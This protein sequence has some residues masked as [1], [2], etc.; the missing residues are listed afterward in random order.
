MVRLARRARSS[1][2]PSA[3]G[4]DA[5]P[6]PSLRMTLIESTGW[7]K[8]LRRIPA[9]ETQAA[10]DELWFAIAVDHHENAALPRKARLHDS[11]LLLTY[12]TTQ[13]SLAERL[14]D[15]R[16]DSGAALP[17]PALVTLRAMSD[18]CA[19]ATYYTCL[20]ELSLPPRGFDGLDV[21][22]AGT[23]GRLSL[24]ML[25]ASTTV[26]LDQ[27][28][29]AKSVGMLLWSC[30]TGLPAADARKLSEIRTSL[31][32]AFCV[33]VDAW[34]AG[35]EEDLAVVGH[36]LKQTVYG[37]LGAGGLLPV[38]PR[39]PRERLVEGELDLLA[40]LCA[41]GKNDLVESYFREHEGSWREEEASFRQGLSA[42]RG[43]RSIPQ[44]TPEPESW[45]LDHAHEAAARAD[46]LLTEAEL[47]TACGEPATGWA[48]WVRA[49][50]VA[51]GEPDT[52]L[53]LARL[54]RHGGGDY[55][56]VSFALAEA[57]CCARGEPAVRRLAKRFLASG[58]RE[59]ALFFEES[60]HS[61]VGAW[62]R[63]VA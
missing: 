3:G 56:G 42:F 33:A 17:L 2:V 23:H 16:L 22:W 4:S 40:V 45:L 52:W 31:P 5:G 14:E 19:C 57:I 59:L 9:G 28:H 49:A 24:T 62:L 25:E 48:A 12:D 37:L 13:G 38:A 20:H 54:L 32:A 47:M 7:R 21:L 61:P 27:R 6:P 44:R 41:L 36:I 60:G 58:D 1:G 53:S 10:V 18:A 46:A 50:S 51:P 29:A 63:S 35:A 34:R 26:D 11:E 43:S 30:L 8:Q 39:L 55:R 15:T